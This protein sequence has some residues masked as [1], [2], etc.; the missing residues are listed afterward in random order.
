MAM[1]LLGL[2]SS[3]YGFQGKKVYE[4]AKQVFD[5]GFETV[6]LGAGHNPEQGVW[7]EI[8]R[9]KRDFP[10]KNYTLH[11]LFPPPKEKTWFNASEGLTKENIETVENFF[12]AAEI[13]EAKVVSVHPGFTEKLKWVEGVEPMS[14]PK[15]QAKIDV[16]KAWLDFFELVEKCVE[17]AEDVGCVFAI[18]N[19]P[20][21]AI[22]LVYSVQ[23]F[24]RVFERIPKLGFMLDIGHALYDRLLLDFLDAHSKRISQIHMH[25]TRADGEAAKTDEHDPITSIEQIKALN[26]VKQF[27]KIP[28]IFEHGTN[29][30]EKQILAEKK[31][32][33]EF[34][35]GF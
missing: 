33:E 2:S 21:I 14:Q 18:E 7:D 8:K 4:S 24:E 10:N 15:R 32:V 29:I 27:N 19:L 35:K 6:E 9:L 31:L 23:D 25:F 34:G 28:V 17:L 13:V 20:K 3:Y 26:V 5:L 22:P 1:N 12:K 30:S 16:E 11:G